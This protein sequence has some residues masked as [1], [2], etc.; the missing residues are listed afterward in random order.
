MSLALGYTVRFFLYLLNT[1]CKYIDF[2][3]CGKF[4]NRMALAKMLLKH[5][6]VHFDRKHQ[7]CLSMNTYSIFNFNIVVL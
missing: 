7:I 5:D 6:L 3:A 1:H 2:Q 4:G